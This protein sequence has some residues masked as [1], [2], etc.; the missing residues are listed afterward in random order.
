[1]C[2]DN[3]FNGDG[4]YDIAYVAHNEDARTLTVLLSMQHEFDVEFAPDVLALEPTEFTQPRSPST[5]A[6]S[7]SR[8]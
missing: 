5:A 3:D 8:A 6:C 2:V 1:M 4:T 7:S